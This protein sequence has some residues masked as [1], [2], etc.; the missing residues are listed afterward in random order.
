M[1]KIH[2]AMQ[3][4]RGLCVPVP[5]SPDVSHEVTTIL[6]SLKPRASTVPSIKE[7]QLIFGISLSQ[8][9]LELFGRNG[10]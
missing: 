5:R 3:G 10:L 4:I 6:Y 9:F 1:D 2:Q 8:S 7:N